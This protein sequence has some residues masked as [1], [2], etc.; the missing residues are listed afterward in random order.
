MKKSTILFA[1]SALVFLLFGVLY[2]IWPLAPYYEE[3]IGM[4]AAE[5]VAGHPEIADLMLTLVNVT[6]LS[7]LALGIF[8]FTLGTLTWQNRLVW[9]S[10]LAVVIIFALPLTYIVAETGGPYPVVIV[11]IL[12][13][14]I[15]LILAVRERN[16]QAAD[17]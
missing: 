17:T 5:F 8:T 3:A 7:F 6:G 15:G 1:V 10:L 9:Y 16:N 13:Q 12:L 11:V 14:L 4:S 2:L